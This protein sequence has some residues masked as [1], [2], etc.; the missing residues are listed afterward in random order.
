MIAAARPTRSTRRTIDQNLI[1]PSNLPEPRGS[2]LV[3]RPSFVILAARRVVEQIT[4]HVT[5][6]LSFL[7]SRAQPRD[8]QFRGHFLETPNSILKQNCHLA[9]PGVPWDR[10]VAQWRDLRFFWVNTDTSSST[11]YS[12]PSRCCIC[13]RDTPFVSG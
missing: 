8:L 6:T 7:S 9:C 13:S 4:F 3:E 1:L 5:T 12:I 10:S 2:F 11:T